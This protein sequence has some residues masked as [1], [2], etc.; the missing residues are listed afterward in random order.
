MDATWSHSGCVMSTMSVAIA[1][2]SATSGKRV[3]AVIFWSRVCAASVRMRPIAA[4]EPCSRVLA[5]TRI[6]GSVV[7][8]FCTAPATLSRSASVRDSETNETLRGARIAPF[9]TSPTL[10]VTVAG[11]ARSSAIAVRMPAM[12]TNA[13]ARARGS[14]RT[15]VRRRARRGSPARIRR[16]TS[17]RRPSRSDRTPAR[18][19]RRARGERH[20]DRRS[21]PWRSLRRRR[22]SRGRGPCRCGLRRGRS[23]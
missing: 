11:G 20:R 12:T 5:L 15:A 14:V 3:S 8:C 10:Y 19:G 13:P 2:V 6:A 17:V 21:R 4:T 18:C 9:A 16:I 1:V 7:Y 22:E 23:A